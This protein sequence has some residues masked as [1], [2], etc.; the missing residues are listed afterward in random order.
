MSI[1]SLEELGGQGL[2]R[3]AFHQVPKYFLELPRWL[4]GRESAHP[5]GNTGSI[6][7]LEEDPREGNAFRASLIA[8]VI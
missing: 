1:T 2:R 3:R 6:P 8:P 5:A 7:G 4:S